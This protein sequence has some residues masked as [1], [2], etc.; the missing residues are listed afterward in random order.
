ML[1]I[2]LIC[3][4]IELYEKLIALVRELMELC[5]KLETS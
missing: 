1:F 2:S 3:Y 4:L 5:I